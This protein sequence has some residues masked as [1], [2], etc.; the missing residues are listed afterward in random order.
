MKITLI[1]RAY[2]P[3]RGRVL[4]LIKSEISNMISELDAEV[5]KAATDKRGHIILSITGE[6]EEFIANVLDRE[7]GIVPK[8]EN[9][10]IGQV[11]NGYLVDVGKVGYGLYVNVGVSKP[12]HMDALLPLHKIRNQLE[13]P[14]TPLRKIAKA[15]ILVDNL[16]VEVVLTGID[17][18]NSKIEAEFSKQ[19]LDRIERWSKDDHERLLV[20]GVTRELLDRVLSKSGHEGDI[21]RI[22]RIGPF[23]YSLR[24]KRSTRAS[25]IVTAIGPKLRGVPMHLVIPREM[26]AIRDAKT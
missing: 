25:G 2:G 16:P 18:H 1:A 5:Q 6:E 12:S 11:E 19:T 10:T 26:E 8:P 3:Y 20:F 15:L 21:Y 9:L 4:G 14:K 24:C 22:E 23:E 7:Y 17:T 13:M